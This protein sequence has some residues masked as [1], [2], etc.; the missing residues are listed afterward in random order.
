[1]LCG[2]RNPVELAACREFSHRCLSHWNSVTS[3]VSELLGLGLLA[4]LLAAALPGALALHHLP[5]AV[6][7]EKF[8][9][10]GLWGFFQ[11]GW[12]G[13]EGIESPPVHPVQAG[14]VL[15]KAQGFLGVGRFPHWSLRTAVNLPPTPT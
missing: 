2:C 10:C 11:T 13:P 3:R 1:M 14:I 7:G 5:D 6:L 15:P 9:P 12:H 4:A 8:A